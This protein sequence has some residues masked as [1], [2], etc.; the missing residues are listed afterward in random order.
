MTFRNLARAG[1][2]GLLAAG[3]LA[4]AAVPALAADVDFGINLTGTTIA[5]DASGKLGFVTV[6]NDGTAKPSDVEVLFDVTDLDQTKVKI[7]LGDCTFTNDVADCALFPEDI[8]GPGAST[9]LPIPLIKQAGAS[10]A[11]GKLTITVKVAGDTNPDNDS[12]TVDVTV[13][14][15]GVDLTVVTPDV[16]LLPTNENSTGTE[17]IPPGGQGLLLAF[18]ANQGDAVADGLKIQF[19]VPTDVTLDENIPGCAYTASRRSASCTFNDISLIPLDQDQTGD[20]ST[21]AFATVVTVSKDA[22]GPVALKGGEVTV[23]A[24][25]QE[26]ASAARIR[27][28]ARRGTPTL[29]KNFRHLTADQ[30]KAVDVDATDNTDTFAVFVAG[31]PGGS[32]GGEGNGGNGNGDDGGLPVTGPVAASVA[33]A[34]AAVIAIGAVLFVVTRR[35]R[36]VMVTPGDE[37]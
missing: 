20:H 30:V 9:K 23:A 21:L 32:G 27:S 5:A 3:T 14:G 1:A 8:P 19:S 26:V 6:T 29:P 25:D 18:I 11:A 34:G 2:T 16:Y 17:P 10:G 31:S 28:M 24:I 36:I 15:N 37:K 7:D 22:K 4:F 12:K 13:G 33:G 35:R